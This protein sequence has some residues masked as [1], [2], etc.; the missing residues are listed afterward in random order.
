VR[1]FE[2]AL[3][4][5]LVW[6]VSVL[7]VASGLLLAIQMIAAVIGPFRLRDIGAH[8]P[9]ERVALWL[10]RG[11]DAAQV[12]RW[13]HWLADPADLRPA[14]ALAA[15]DP[16][17]T[18]AILLSEPRALDTAG[19]LALERYVVAGGGVVVTG[20]LGVRDARGEWLGWDL[21]RSL[22]GGAEVVP[23]E[24]ERAVALM[25]ARRGPLVAPVEPGRP[26]GV[27]PEAG[28]P[29]LLTA[30]AELRWAPDA[31]GAPG[32]AA[33]LR[34][35]LGAGRIAWLAV[36]PER[37][38]PGA[39]GELPLAEVLEAALAWASRRPT[40]ELLPW[41]GGAPFA[42]TVEPAA[43]AE[44]APDPR[45][46]LAAARA[47]GGLAALCASSAPD[48]LPEALAEVA[49]GGGWLAT[50]SGLSAWTQQ[51]SSL[52]VA[53]RRVGPTRLLVSV[54]NRAREP[55]RGA[56]LRVHLNQRARRVDLATTA[57]LQRHAALRF[58]PREQQV[59]LVL[60]ELAARRSA[61]YTIDY[62]VLDG[63]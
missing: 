12:A 57:I 59:D 2:S 18:G 48:A 14:P 61:A 62:E 42:A 11:A 16:G 45:A 33:S 52:D 49:R 31:S 1:P 28:L 8:D 4:R 7:L 53:V 55:V 17:R 43:P 27:Q 26:L 15:L 6:S 46:T 21:M 22:L 20:A 13:R 35:T 51:R 44:P 19:V 56:V 40:A 5:P 54:S 39:A 29:G 63:A 24:A 47:S 60:P 58:R 9:R 34:R 25:A 37:A 38:A 30:D 32:P 10:P 3:Y 23:V 41:P 50:R 36:G